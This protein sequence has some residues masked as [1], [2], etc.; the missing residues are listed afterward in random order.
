[1]RKFVFVGACVALVILL[2]NSAEGKGN[3]SPRE[4][5]E[6]GSVDAIENEAT[7]AKHKDLEGVETVVFPADSGGFSA[8]GGGEGGDSAR[9]EEEEVD[10]GEEQS[11]ESEAS[12][13][14]SI[15][16]EKSAAASEK[17]SPLLQML[18]ARAKKLKEA[19]RGLFFAHLYFTVAFLLKTFFFDA[20]LD[21]S[22]G[23][24]Q[25]ALGQ[26]DIRD[27]I[28]DIV[29]FYKR[30]INGKRR[31]L[32]LLTLCFLSIHSKI[33]LFYK[34]VSF[35]SSA[36]SALFLRYKQRQSQ[37]LEDDQAPALEA[38]DEASVAEDP[39]LSSSPSEEV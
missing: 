28:Q 39:E 35:V 38:A 11:S 34:L 20:L 24:L 37:Q 32:P 14:D 10:V 16:D 6:E 1:M 3:E 4:V 5:S 29:R 19:K 15:E 8:A 36:A 25:A 33:L 7:H 21:D 9:Q 22:L 26:E 31:E 13:A 27:H 12:T 18:E 2:T 30:H 23:E 17:V